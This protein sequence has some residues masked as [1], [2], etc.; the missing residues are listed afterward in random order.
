MTETQ[1]NRYTLEVLDNG[2]VS[3][4]HTQTGEILHGSVGPEKEAT[5]LYID[6]SGLGKC[7]KPE[8]VVFDVGTGCGAQLM[9]LLD[10][11]KISL[12]TKEIHVYSFDLEKEG[13]RAALEARKQFPSV[14]RNQL[15]L[16]KALCENSFAWNCGE[17][18]KLHWNFIG[19]DFRETIQSLR[20]REP[21]LRADFIFYDF[22]SPASHPWLWTFD[23]FEK[24]YFYCKETTH[25]VTY[26]SATSV[27]AALA[28]AGWF[29]GTTIPS[30]KKAQSIFAAGSRGE[31]AH[32]LPTQFISTFSL[33]HKPFCDAETPESQIEIRKKL[34][35]HPQFNDS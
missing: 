32:L 27:K 1:G 2:V 6:A 33:S 3:F 9:A 14:E 23:L 35:C 4:R 28:A 24:L 8:V 30:G 15:F 19:G 7:S 11:L 21:Q 16:E 25:L 17:N 20:A 10:F 26:S 13:L 5:E 29:V 22:F 18:K 31:V 12:S 34:S